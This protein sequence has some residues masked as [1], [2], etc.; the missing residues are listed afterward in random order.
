MYLI[1]NKLLHSRPKDLFHNETFKRIALRGALKIEIK[2][3]AF[4]Y[5][6]DTEGQLVSVQQWTIQSIISSDTSDSQ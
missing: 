5:L 2:N 6:I 3:C 4:A 1:Y